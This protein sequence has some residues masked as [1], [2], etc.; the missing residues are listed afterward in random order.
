MGVSRSSFSS[1]PACFASSIYTLLL[2]VCDGI[3]LEYKKRKKKR[4]EEI[5]IRWSLP[6]FVDLWWYVWDASGVCLARAY[7][8]FSFFSYGGN[9][10]LFLFFFFW[11]ELWPNYTG[12]IAWCPRVMET[13]VYSFHFFPFWIFSF[14]LEENPLFFIVPNWLWKKWD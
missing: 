13:R 5:A 2:V 11:L 6:H 10:F 3:P 1:C 12:T 4:K 8:D 9:C 7:C 14:V